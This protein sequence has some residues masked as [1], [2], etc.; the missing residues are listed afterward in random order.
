MFSLLLFTLGGVA[1]GVFTGLVPGIHPNTVIFTA[2]PYYLSSGIET[3]HFV[4]FLT[5]MSVSHTFH[6]FLPAFFIS[7]P[8]AE[9]A[10]SS[11]SAAEMVKSG[12]GLEAFRYTVYG[13]LFSLL[14]VMLFSALSFFYL[15][16]L[17]GWISGFMEHILLFFLFFMVLDSENR[18]GSALV[19]V[20]AG[21]LGVA[22]FQSPVNQNFVFIPL[23][24]GLFAVPA[25]ISSLR[26]DY[27][28]PDQD[29]P[30]LKFPEAFRGG[31]VGSA[32]GFLAGVIPGIGA[33]VSTSFLSPLMDRS[34]RKFMASMG[35]VNTTDIIFSLVALY[36]IERA[37]SGVSVALELLG[38]EVNLVLVGVLALLSVFVSAFTA[39]KV[40][41]RYVDSLRSVQAEKLLYSVLALLAAVVFLVTGILGLLVFLTSSLVGEA[42]LRTGNRKVCM[43]VLIVPAILYFAGFGIFM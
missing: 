2:V 27:K 10:L 5:G 35:A 34:R 22:S 8:D 24:S 42:A 37:R 16:Q 14:P 12:K 4:A 26:S 9:S 18:F 41:G 43:A 11:V 20:F 15:E 3:M 6:D 7:A 23:F 40:S 33:A 21:A 25:I 1:A 32:A 29:P 31:I 17:Y 38:S 39:L 13:A 19:A 30:S 36:L 28:I